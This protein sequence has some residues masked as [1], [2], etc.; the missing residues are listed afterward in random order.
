MDVRNKMYF[1]EDLIFL[2]LEFQDKFAFF[3]YIGQKLFEK[4]VVHEKFS[5]EIAKREMK[6]PT[7]LPV[8]PDAVA[9]PHCNPKFVIKNTISIV[10][11]KEKVQF[12]E[13]GTLDKKINVKF[14][15]VLTMN[16][17]QEVPILQ[18]LLLLFNNRDFMG[19]IH[20]ANE[21]EVF[22]LIQNV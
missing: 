19:K 11:F 15:F 5:E 7:G 18:E 2:D 16:A 20:T 3:K 4:Q 13:M 8:S 12:C 10:R 22:E 21:K 9:I 14:A 1:K 6:Y 17:L